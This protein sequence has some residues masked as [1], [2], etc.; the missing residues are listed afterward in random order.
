MDT[1]EPG[2]LYVMTCPYRTGR[3]SRGKEQRVLK[4]TPCFLIGVGECYSFSISWAYRK[5]AGRTHH[6]L[7][8]GEVVDID[9][10]YDRC[11]MEWREL[12]EE[13]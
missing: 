13:L 5:E 8:G 9:I 2:K 7:V 11:D 3:N 1:L 6:F 10:D 4:G 12:K